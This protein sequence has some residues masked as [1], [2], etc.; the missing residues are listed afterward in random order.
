M[1]MNS[2]ST[3]HG[4]SKLLF[5]DIIFNTRETWNERNS[6]NLDF[7]NQPYRK[8]KFSALAKMS[9]LEATALLV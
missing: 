8:R 4:T 1:Q 3:T 9:Q 7:K 6:E 5:L 2:S